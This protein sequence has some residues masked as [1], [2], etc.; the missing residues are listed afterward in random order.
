MR[1]GRKTRAILA[2]LAE[3][4]EP[5]RRLALQ[6][7]FSGQARDPAGALRW[8]LSRIRSSAGLP[9]LAE[10]DQGVAV[11]P[12]YLAVDTRLFAAALSRERPGLDSLKKALERWQGDF[13][14]SLH[15]PDS[16]D[17]DLWL[18]GARARYSQ[19]YE[20]GLLQLVSEFIG[21][22]QLEP[23]IEWGRRLT[24]HNPLLEEGH[25]RL[26][27]LYARSGQREAALA[28]IEICRNLLREEL[29]VLPS[30]ELEALESQLRAGSDTELPSEPA[31]R[32]A[33][34]LP[35]PVAF[36]G[37]G[38]EWSELEDLRRSADRGRGQA[39]LIAGEAGAG[40]T[41]LV[42]EFAA[43]TGIPLWRA[44]AFESSRSLPY[45]PWIELLEDLLGGLEPEALGGLSMVA[46]EHLGRLIPS[47][48]AGSGHGIPAPPPTHGGA[49][50]RL[51]QSVAEILYDLP[52]RSQGP[53]AGIIFLDDMQWADESSL[54]LF[55]YASRRI[56]QEPRLLI[57]TYRPEER[58]DNPA[59]Q[60]LLQD[61]RRSGAPSIALQPLKNTEILDLLS[62]QW[63]ALS[64][65]FRPHLG[66]LL[67]QS[68]GGNPF[69]LTETIRELA[70]SS[71]VP[72]SLPVPESVVELI[73]RRLQLLPAGGRQVIET[74]A[75]MD[76]PATPKRIQEISARSEAETFTAIDQGMRRGLLKPAAPASDRY[77]FAHDLVRRAV[78]GDMSDLRAG[79]LHRRTAEALSSA[80][81]PAARLA[82]H[83]Q[84]AGDT[85]REAQAALEAGDQ[86]A[87]VYAHEQ[88]IRYY[89]RAARI[90]AQPEGR[91]RAQLGLGEVRQLASAWAEAE[92]HA[93]AA[94]QI[95]E[96]IGAPAARGRCLASLGRL[97]TRGGRFNEAREVLEEAERLFRQ[98][99]DPAGIGEAIRSLGLVQW[100]LGDYD[101]ARSHLERA[102]RLAQESGDRK[103]EGIAIGN[104][105]IVY[106]SQRDYEKALAHYRLKQQMDEEDGDRLSASQAVGNIG[107]VHRDRGDYP[108]AMESYLHKLAIDQELGDRI[109]VCFA[110]ENMADLYNR[111]GEYEKAL[112][113]AAHGLQIALELDARQLVSIVLGRLVDTYTGQADQERLGRT[114]RQSV[115]INRWMNLPR[116]LCKSLFALASH[117][118]EAGD[119]D[120]AGELLEEC[121][122][123]A[124]GVRHRRVQFQAEKLQASLPA[125]AD[126]PRRQ[127]AIQQLESLEAEWTL[128]SEQAALHDAIWQL[129]PRQ[130]DRRAAAISAYESL[131]AR[132][133]DSNVRRRLE[134]LTG[135][136]LPDPDPLPE[137]P[138]AIR[139][140]LPVLAA[141]LEQVGDL[142]ASLE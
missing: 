47:L 39:I 4:G 42:E 113:C 105:G 17:F 35:G 118:A 102:R 121:I 69:F 135:E 79:L 30:P 76:E 25:R 19:L 34:P 59:L 101:S 43:S 33:A 24:A 132:S 131:Y 5:H 103:G 41:R 138:E 141:L 116:N 117:Q 83:W 125:L 106:W 93:R 72:E 73:R 137:L 58:E 56:R 49:A 96:E 128:E 100:Y 36:V 80:G 75:V 2:Y 120:L 40:K 123:L 109:G 13:L 129:D 37:R 81:A 115:A 89:E 112:H 98:A 32:P 74:F 8:H 111:R 45:R 87:E 11:D 38:R 50:L 77:D 78:L 133:S 70:L 12:A 62:A 95:A 124:A 63:P 139:T 68:T 90:S 18:L 82:Y 84:R 107:L 52:H 23:A 57:G 44:R 6:N 66:A 46:R 97:M 119:L 130:A 65:G 51:H 88:A 1:L 94:L 53:A 15:L 16:P 27:W 14:E 64:P 54:Q 10:S 55:H 3:T 22:G 110:L 29:G 86:A 126:P 28:Q 122:R 114:A 20:R 9:L 71:D 7:M 104:T 140:S 92:S 85:E 127:E 91:M 99:G 31:A 26:A 142:I 21:R 67:A 108:R 60:T 134:A 48:V 61:L 136:A